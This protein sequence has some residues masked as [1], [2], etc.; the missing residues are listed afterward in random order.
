MKYFIR[1][2]KYFVYLSVLLVLFIYILKVAGL[3]SGSID[4]MF[5]NGTKSIPMMAL[6]VAVFAA[7]YPQLGFSSRNVPIRGPFSEIEPKITDFMHRRGYILTKK[8]GEN[9]VYRK[10]SGFDRIIKMWEDKITFTR[11]LGGFSIEGLTKEIVRIDTGL[12]QLF[13]DTDE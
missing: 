10:S 11:T 1:A 13:P 4:D 3:I 6:I 7:I 2:V 5:I 9:L 8:D 12:A